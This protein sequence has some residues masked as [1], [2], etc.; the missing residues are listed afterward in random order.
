VAGLCLGLALLVPAPPAGAAQSPPLR[1]VVGAAEVPG[2]LAHRIV[3][4]QDANQPDMALLTLP[5]RAGRQFAAALAVGDDM[6][7][8]GA[9]ARPVFTGEVVALE[10]DGEGRDRGVVVRA[11]NRIHRLDRGAQTRTF[12][13]ASDADIVSALAAEHGLVPV[14]APGLDIRHEAV[15][16][17]NQSDLEFLRARAARLGFEVWC[18]DTRLLFGPRD[19]TPVVLSARPRV[20]GAVR[21]ER[22]HPRLSSTQSV[23]RVIVR[24][25]DPVKQVEIVGEATAP[26]VLI[27]PG[28]PGPLGR[29]ETFTVDHPIFSVAE[30]EGLARTHL[31]ELLAGGLPTEVETA[32]S[33]LLRAGRLVAVHGSAAPFNGKYLVQGVSHRYA[34]PDGCGGGYRTLLAVRRADAGLFFLP[35]IDDEVL[36]AFEAGDLGRPYVVGSLWNGDPDDCPPAE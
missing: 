36:V 10:P 27:G 31:A 14:V 16:Q 30:A 28:A 34:H 19:E 33:A 21:L 12:A 17:H 22:F 23:Q 2:G 32:G 15:Y 7:I 35:E 8:D 26:T 29:T 9:G 1:A 3:V 13:D 4:E 18:E 20:R 5:E 11:K 24:G 6:W 25:W